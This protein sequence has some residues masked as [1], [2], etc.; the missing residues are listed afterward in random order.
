M[1]LLLGFEAGSP[2]AA[3]I[4]ALPCAATAAP[5]S[6]GKVRRHPHQRREAFSAGYLRLLGRNSLSVLCALSLLSLSGQTVR[7]VYGGYL[8]S[9]AF[10]VILGVLFLGFIAW[11]AEWRKTL[12]AD[13]A[14]MP[15]SP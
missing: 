4:P 5:P 15:L 7:L 12:R 10:A 6:R 8:A 1:T 2:A 9:G 14:S 3:S 13:L 11:A